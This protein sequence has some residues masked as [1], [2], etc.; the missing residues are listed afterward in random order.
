ML[1][2]VHHHVFMRLFGTERADSPLVTSSSRLCLQTAC[3]WVSV[4]V[5]HCRLGLSLGKGLHKGVHAGAGVCG[6]GCHVAALIHVLR[7]AT[8]AHMLSRPCLLCIRH[9]KAPWSGWVSCRMSVRCSTAERWSTLGPASS[10]PLRCDWGRL[11]VHSWSGELGP[12]CYTE[13][14][15]TVWCGGDVIKTGH[16]PCC[17]LSQTCGLL[18]SQGEH[19][20][21]WPGL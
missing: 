5:Q 19:W 3:S 12:G 16:C 11:R 17:V 2:G 8:A 10:G 20:E 18:P 13:I 6:L 1:C 7:K 15:S 21:G 4:S 9:S 14:L